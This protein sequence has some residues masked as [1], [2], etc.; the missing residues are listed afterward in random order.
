MK[1]FSYRWFKSLFI[2]LNHFEKDCLFLTVLLVVVIGWITDTVLFLF[3]FITVDLLDFCVRDSEFFPGSLLFICSCHEMFLSCVLVSFSMCILFVFCSSKLGVRN[4]L[5]LC[6]SWWFLFSLSSFRDN[7]AGYSNLIYFQFLKY[8]TS[9]FHVFLKSLKTDRLV[10]I[11]FLWCFSF[12]YELVFSPHTMSSIVCSIF[13]VA[14]LRYVIE[15]LF[16]AHVF[17]ILSAFYL[18]MFIFPLYV[19]LPMVILEPISSF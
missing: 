18:L 17:W 19:S 4:C 6:L 15:R 5:N 13:F 12:V 2:I 10:N 9:C 14:W 1:F 16:S 3:S 7:F 8:I 11:W